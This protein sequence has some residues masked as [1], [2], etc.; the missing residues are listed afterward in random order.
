MHFTRLFVPLQR[1]TE[2]TAEMK[3]LGYIFDYGGTLDT[4]GMHWGQ[5]L[6]HAYEGREVPVTQQQYREAYVYGE[7][8]LGRNPIIKPDFTFRQTLEAKLRLQLEHL[9][10]GELMAYLP[11]LLDDVYAKTQQHTAHSVD[12]LGQLITCL[13]LGSG[14][15][16]PYFFILFF[17]LIND[18]CLLFS[19]KK[20]LAEM[21]CHVA[22][23]PLKVE[24]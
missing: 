16:P 5:V 23:Q 8:T 6:W 10:G 12:V 14:H 21:S 9:G 20:K 3:V 15:L 1:E 19:K 2:T 11:L 17:L 13:V 24:E 22:F 7:R 18:S 4:G